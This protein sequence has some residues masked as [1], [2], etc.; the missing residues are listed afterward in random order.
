M[1][2]KKNSI[3]MTGLQTSKVNFLT[4][5]ILISIFICGCRTTTFVHEHYPIIS[6]P[7][8]PAI[9]SELNKEDFISMA[10]YTQK[11]EVGIKKYNE[12]AKNKNEQLDILLEKS[13]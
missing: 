3:W 12:Y 5:M 10:K 11:L 6:I 7:G 1:K 13:R 9:S 4:F 2:L 8:R